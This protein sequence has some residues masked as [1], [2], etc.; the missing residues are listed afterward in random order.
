MLK[1]FL[2]HSSFPDDVDKVVDLEVDLI[3]N[4]NTTRTDIG[5]KW[6]EPHDP[7]GAVVSY[8][9]A[10]LSSAPDSVEEKKCITDKVF[11]NA[12]GGYIYILRALPS[13]NYSIRVQANSLAGEGLYSDPKYIVIPVRAKSKVN[14]VYKNY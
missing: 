9:I 14:I 10:Y 13:G 8:T 6:G 3:T 7:N 5:I 11:H 4:T 1:K 2:L 12:T